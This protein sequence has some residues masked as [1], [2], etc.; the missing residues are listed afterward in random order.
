MELIWKNLRLPVEEGELALLPLMAH[1]LKVPLSSISGLHIV[2]RSLDA[3]KKPSLFFVYTIRFVLEV[4]KHELKRILARQSDITAVA[5]EAAPVVPGR[6]EKLKYRPLIIGTGPAGYLAALTLARQGYQPLVLERGDMVEERTRKVEEFWGSGTLDPESNVQFGEGGA[7]T[8][9][10]GKLTT[11]IHD[12]RMMKVMDVFVKHGAPAEIRYLAKPH[13]GTDILKAVVRGI[14]QE[15]EA[16]G[17]TIMFRAKV[18][19]LRQT[20]GQIRSIIINGADE[21]PAECVVLATGHSARDLY[22]F[23]HQAGVVMTGKPF[24]IGLR[25]EHPQELINQAQYGVDAHPVLGPADYQLTYQDLPTGRGA[26]AFCMCPG[27]RVV[28]AA[29]EPGGVVTNGMSV[30]RRD[31]GI[32]NSALVVTVGRE[33]FSSGHP[34]AG[35]EFQR[36]WEH[37]AFVVAGSNYQAPVQSAQDFLRQRVGEPVGLASYTPGVVP[38]EL[39]EVLPPAVGEVM[40]RALSSF[41]RKIPGFAGDRAVLTGVETRTSAP[42]RIVRDEQGESNWK[43]L[44]PAG[45]GAGYAG[46]IMSAAVD[47][48]RIAEKIISRYEPAGQ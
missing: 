28:A 34:L 18:T 17:G 25:I 30:Y 11:R 16:L 32:A 47:G 45:E 23:L 19:E 10:D 42:V 46:G 44:F 15:I 5:E 31:S 43:G 33:D 1:K 29:S 35:I 48:M 4:S 41:D 20:D 36:V 2:R 12:P 6:R 38:A 8:F 13:I 40:D 39:H 9:S 24:A 26:Y 22:A 27:G 21:I 7:G 3:R 37:K 14:R